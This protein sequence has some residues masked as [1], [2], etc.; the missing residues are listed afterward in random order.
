MKSQNKFLYN[1]PVVEWIER[2]LIKKADSGTIPGW[3]K[4]KTIKIGFHNFPAW[5]SALK[6]QCEAPT[7]CVT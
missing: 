2:L 5:H 1:R 7:V 4:P 3:T 6:G